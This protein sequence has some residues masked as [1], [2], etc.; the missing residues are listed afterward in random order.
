MLEFIDNPSL[1]VASNP[2][3]PSLPKYPKSNASSQVGL[4]CILSNLRRC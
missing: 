3:A 2:I 1:K 4:H